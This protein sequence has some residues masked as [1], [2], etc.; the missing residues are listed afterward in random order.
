[1]SGN[2]SVTL[3][4]SLQ[5]KAVNGLG[6]DS[7]LLAVTAALMKWQWLLGLADTIL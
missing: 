4:C 3:L 6:L 1:M 5:R 7:L 2:S